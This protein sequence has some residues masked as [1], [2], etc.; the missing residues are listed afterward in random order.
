LKKKNDRCGSLRIGGE[1]AF[2]MQ[3]AIV[4][5]RNPAQGMLGVL[6]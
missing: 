6:G 2:A 3:R 1:G 4:R 5:V